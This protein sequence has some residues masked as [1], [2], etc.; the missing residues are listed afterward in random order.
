M[1]NYLQIMLTYGSWRQLF[2]LGGLAL[3]TVVC[4]QPYRLI[5]A[6]QPGTGHCREL[7]YG[8]GCI[9]ASFCF[10]GATFDGVTEQLLYSMLEL[11]AV[12][13][14]DPAGAPAPGF[15]RISALR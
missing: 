15:E 11:L 3:V 7:T 12:G 13:N 1:L 4:V 14:A 8:S 9:Y 10:M 6:G 2:H 5:F